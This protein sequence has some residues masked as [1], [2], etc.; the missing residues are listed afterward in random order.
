VVVDDVLPDFPQPL[1]QAMSK[2]ARAMSLRLRK[3]VFIRT[4]VRGESSPRLFGS[5]SSWA[6]IVPEIFHILC[7]ENG[8][9]FCREQIVERSSRGLAFVMAL[10]RNV[11]VRKRKSPKMKM[12]RDYRGGKI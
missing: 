10:F 12:P 9:G 11:T 4:P 1:K 5:L 6:T 7:S 8:F 3:I 2:S